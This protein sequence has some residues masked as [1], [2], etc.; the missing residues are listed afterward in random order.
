[1]RTIRTPE[2]R[3]AFLSA[4]AE[5]GN[6]ADAA[7]LA[8]VARNALY[9]WKKDDPDFAAEWEAALAAGGDSLEEEAIRR[10]RDGWEEPVFY[11]G[12]QVST[13]R[14]Y[15]DTLMIFLLKGLMP[16]KYGERHQVELSG[17]VDFAG[18]LAAA[19]ERAKKVNRG[20]QPGAQPEE[21]DA[22]V[23]E[24]DAAAAVVDL[25]GRLA[26]KRKKD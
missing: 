25:A 12:Q 11:Q 26:A 9:L 14:R 5:C 17:S 6:V 23:Q 15:S 21:G 2:K 16:Q 3:S 19:R 22:P 10:A 24:P 8:Q 1:M 18:R 13:V 7:R 20:Q 4:L